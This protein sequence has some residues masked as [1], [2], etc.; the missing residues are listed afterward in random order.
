MTHRAHT[1]TSVILRSL[2]RAELG[3]FYGVA[4]LTLWSCRARDQGSGPV[5]LDVHLV[6]VTQQEYHQ[7]YSSANDDMSYVT[8]M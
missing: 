5:F 8:V 2:P 1:V 7:R 4:S 3:L 6:S